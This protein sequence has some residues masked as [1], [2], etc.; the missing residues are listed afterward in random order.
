MRATCL[1]HIILLDLIILITLLSLVQLAAGCH[2]RPEKLIVN[3]LL[4]ATSSLIFFTPKDLKKDRGSYLVCCF[5][6]VHVPHMLLTLKPYRKMQVFQ[7]KTVSDTS[8]CR[9]KFKIICNSIAIRAHL[10]KLCIRAYNMVICHFWRSIVKDNEN[11]LFVLKIVPGGISWS[12]GPTGELFLIWG[13]KKVGSPWLNLII[14]GTG[15]VLLK[16]LNTLKWRTRV[17]LLH[18]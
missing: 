6:Y 10:N 13:K 7:V 15:I 14:C 9:S 18:V 11:W 4:I 3:L 1:A 8:C 2:I 16:R 17:L 12:L 5:T